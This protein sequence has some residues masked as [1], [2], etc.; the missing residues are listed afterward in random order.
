MQAVYKSEINRDVEVARPKEFAPARIGNLTIDPPVILAPMAGVT[1]WPFREL[2]RRFGAGL[3]VSEMITARP[4]A[5][6]REKTLKLADFGP[7][8]SPRSLQLYGVDP[9]YVGIAVKRLVDE[10]RIDHL[11]MNF[12][13]PVPKVTRKGGG[14]AIPAKPLLLASIVRAAVKNAGSIPV[15]IKFRMGIDEDLI[16]YLDAGKIA[17]AEGCAGVSL[18]ARTAAQLYDGEARWEAIGELKAALKIPV[19]GN[20]DIWEAW[21][22]LRMMRETGCDGVVVGRGCLGRPW[23]FRDLADV[24]AGR[25]PQDP[26]RFREVAEIMMEHAS[27]LSEWMGE[28]QAMRM[29]RKHSSWYTKGF[30]GSAPLRAALMQVKTLEELAAALRAH[31]A[32]LPFPPEAMRV[33]RGKTAGRQRVALP[34]GFLENRLTDAT[35]P[36]E[37]PFVEG[38]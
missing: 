38:G 27:M 15:T 20:G 23:L 7:N 35:P 30:R 37:V 2:C 12:G 13:C 34:E 8:E 16:T 24:F 10:G 6:G 14:A 1:N 5:E 32:D 19:F 9:H 3:Y 18:H 31:D 22:A 25:E 21:D 36:V 11:D 17:E 28:R 26:P 29:F 33:P 4:L